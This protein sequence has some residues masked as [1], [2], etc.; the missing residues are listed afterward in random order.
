M[1]IH[2]DSQI[3]ISVV[4]GSL[5]RKS[6]LQETI[7]SIRTDTF[8]GSME[9]IVIDGGSTD[10]TC[11]W[12]AKQTDVFTMIQPNYKI[13]DYDG[14]SRRAHSWG[15]FMNIGFKLAK[16]RW[17]LMVS[18]DLVLCKDAIKNGMEE[19]ETIIRTGEKIGG[20]AMFWREYPRDPQYHVKV[21]PDN[22]IHINHGFYLKEALEDVDYIDETSFEF[23]GADGD[24]S[25]RLNLGGW[26]TVALKS[27]FAEHLNKYKAFPW[28]KKIIQKQWDDSNKVAHVFW[29][30]DP[31][32]C[33]QGLV[34]RYLDKKRY[35]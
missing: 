21:L 3:N 8:N 1:L 7:N 2:K 5:N 16:G 28:E 25:M 14:T 11:E 20:G 23:Y 9:I 22:V 12:L 10:G 27:S 33:A 31:I 15:E 26:K 17:V 29:R 30:R 32:A 35:G 24:L 4:L 34:L 13:Q 19:L 6:L 18:D